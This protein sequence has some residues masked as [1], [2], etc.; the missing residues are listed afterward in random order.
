MFKLLGRLWT[1]VTGGS[2]K[3][4]KDAIQAKAKAKAERRAAHNA[5]TVNTVNAVNSPGRT[6]TYNSQFSIVNTGYKP[7][8]LPLNYGTILSG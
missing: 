3:P 6:R 5:D 2:A 8:V 4:E 1:A 7:A